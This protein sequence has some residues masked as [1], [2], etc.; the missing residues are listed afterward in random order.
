MKS[1]LKKQ[2]EERLNRKFWVTHK[3]CFDCVV[4]METNL[5]NDPEA[6]EKYQKE[7]HR[8]KESAI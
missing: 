4:K 1:L 5:R 2:K 7:R 8:R 3:T 6:W